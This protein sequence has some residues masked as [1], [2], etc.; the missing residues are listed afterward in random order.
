MSFDGLAP[1]YQWLERALAGGKLQRRRTAFLD[2]V[3]QARNALLVGEGPGRFLAE[4]LRRNPTIAVTSV[5][6]SRAMLAVCQTRLRRAG[7][8]ADR[9]RYVEADV[10]NCELPAA[11]YDLVAT[12]FFLDCFPR[13]PLAAVVVKLATATTKDARWLVSDFA[14]PDGGFPRYRA[15]AIHALMYAFF[16]VAARLPARRVE[17]PAPFL[18]ENRFLRVRRETDDLGLL[19]SDLWR[20]L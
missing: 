3:A 8:A 17:P 5:D 9:V 19:Y 6:S 1:H 11:T 20:R 15:K 18:A 14:I 13:A 7:L 10:M 4:L 2:E 16:R 12:H